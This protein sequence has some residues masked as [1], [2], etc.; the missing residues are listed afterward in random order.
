[1]VQAHQRRLRRC[2]LMVERE[3][4]ITPPGDESP[5]RPD[6]A[7]DVRATR[8]L[9]LRALTRARLLVATL[10]LPIGVLFRP[11]AGEESWWVVGWALLAVGM[12][13]ILFWLAI[14]LKRGLGVQT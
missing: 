13:S 3:D 7:A 5:G 9:G 6:S 14:R 12:L 2:Q 10:A 1:D 11:E 4:G 8:W